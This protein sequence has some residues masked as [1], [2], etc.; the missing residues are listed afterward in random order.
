M[1]IVMN[2]KPCCSRV[3]LRGIS[4]TVLNE[5]DE[6]LT[7]D[8]IKTFFEMFHQ[9]VDGQIDP[10][11]VQIYLDKAVIEHS[12]QN[13]QAVE[14]QDNSADTISADVTQQDKKNRTIKNYRFG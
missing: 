6:R 8:E 7:V 9:A 2:K 3:F 10:H 12:K 4:I 5:V 14:V 1:I 11:D 13:V